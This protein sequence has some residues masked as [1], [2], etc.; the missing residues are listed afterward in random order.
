[1]HQPIL[2]PIGE[3][4]LLDISTVWF[5]E[6]FRSQKALHTEDSELP[7]FAALYIIKFYTNYQDFKSYKMAYFLD[8]H[9]CEKYWQWVLTILREKC[10]YTPP[11]FQPFTK[12][13]KEVSML[14]FSSPEQ[15]KRRQEKLTPSKQI[16][17]AR[18]VLKAQTPDVTQMTEEQ[19][20]QRDLAQ[21]RAQ[22]NNPIYNDIFKRKGRYRPP[23]VTIEDL[24]SDLDVVARA[25]AKHY[26]SKSKKNLPPVSEYGL[27]DDDEI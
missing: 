3:F 23:S 21:K 10:G 25:A 5:T 16:Q 12:L 2:I 22:D 9:A 14:F 7:R 8:E 6:R 19:L 1:M 27:G 18:E 4:R 11:P 15:A 17:R 26:R 24:T 20:K 13:P